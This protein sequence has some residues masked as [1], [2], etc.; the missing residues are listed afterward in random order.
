MLPGGIDG[1]D[2]LAGGPAALEPDHQDYIEFHLRTIGCSFC[3][4]NLADLESLQKEPAAKVKQRRRRFFES[5]AGY[6]QAGKA[7]K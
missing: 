2:D 7:K 6:F 5:S 4:A 1:E 3:L